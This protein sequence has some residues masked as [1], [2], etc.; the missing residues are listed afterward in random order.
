MLSFSQAVLKIIIFTTAY[1]ILALPSADLFAT[2]SYEIGIII[3]H[4]LNVRPEPGMENTPVKVLKKGAKVIILE[5]LNGWYKV[6]HKGKIGYIKNQ[7]Q[8]IRTIFVEDNEEIDITGND[9]ST[10]DQYKKEAEKINQK[11]EKGKAEV[12]TFTRN[13]SNIVNSLN[14]IDLELNRARKRIS[15]TKSGL[16][17]LEAKITETT[18]ASKHL[19]KKIKTNEDYASKRL[20]A[21]YKLNWLGKIHFLG[22]AQSMYELFQRKKNMERIMAYDENVRQNLLVNRAKLQQVLDTLNAQKMEKLSLEADLKK[23]V[24]IMSRERAKRQ[25]LLDDIRNKKALEMA[26]I[27]SL[28]QAAIDLDQAIK[29]LSLKS[30]KPEQIIKKLPENF[31]SLKGLLN[32]PV[33]GKIVSFFGQYINDKLNVV[34]FRSGIEIKAD[35]GEPIRAIYD[36]RILYADW[37]KGYGN[38]VIIDHGNNFYSVYAHA[39]ELFTSKGDTVEMGEV[40]ATVGDSGSMIGPALHFEVRH[41]GKPVDPL[42]WIREG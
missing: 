2:Q 14:D 41:H 21:L 24:V 1:F 22:S 4:N 29:S 28:K 20:V 42:E 6:K 40:V 19:M 26:A 18:D 10:I 12:L 7:K 36:G 15:V 30:D 34:N 35:R 23:E 37:F 38:M 25:E 31:P 39:E 3:A 32:M 9:S 27:E 8:Y 16:I 33:N 11:I 13:E 5:H 17:T